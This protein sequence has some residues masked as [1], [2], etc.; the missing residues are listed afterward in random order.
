MGGEDRNWRERE[1]KRKRHIA[2]PFPKSHYNTK[3]Y[4][5]K[6]KKLKTFTPE[7]NVCYQNKCN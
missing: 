6:K 2:A 7:K 4:Y 5:E 3:V 1:R